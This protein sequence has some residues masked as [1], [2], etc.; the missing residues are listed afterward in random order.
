MLLFISWILGFKQYSFFRIARV[1]RR[2]IFDAFAMSAGFLTCFCPIHLSD[3]GKSLDPGMFLRIPPNYA[4]DM[5]KRLAAQTDQ[6]VRGSNP[7]GR[8]ISSGI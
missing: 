1:S 6:K 8:A 5:T 7:F 2:P 3:P 4:G